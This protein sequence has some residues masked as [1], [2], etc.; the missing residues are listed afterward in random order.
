MLYRACVLA[1]L[2]LMCV[3]Q[4]LMLA[5]Q[6]VTLGDF[7]RASEADR[8]ALADRIPVTQVRG[9]VGVT[10]IDPLDVRI[11]RDD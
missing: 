3:M 8:A 9:S 4:A 1:L 11:Q 7:Q 2:A 6:P 5:R 10:T